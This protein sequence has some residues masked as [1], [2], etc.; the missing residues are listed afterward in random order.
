MSDRLAVFLYRWRK[1]LSALIVL[2]AVLF[3]PSLGVITRIDNDITAWFSRDDPVFQQYER[4]RKEFG[5]TR[6]LIVALKA[7]EG[8]V[9]TAERFQFL[10]RAT[11]DIQR[12]RLVQRADS[13]ATTNIV[14]GASQVGGTGVF[15]GGRDRTPSVSAAG[16]NARPSDRSSDDDATLLVRPLSDVFREQGIAAVRRLAMRDDF[17]RGDLVSDDERVVAIVV[18]FDEDRV[19]DVRAQVVDAVHRAVTS[20]LP[21]GLTAHFNGSLEI[22]ETYNRITLD[23]TAKFTPP[24]LL[25][26]LAAIYLMF[27]S[28]RRTALTMF[29][30]LVSVFWT[31]GLYTVIGFTYNVLTSMLVPLIIVL[32]IADDVHIMQHFEHERRHRDAEAAFKATVSH[33]FAPLLGASVTTAL[34]MLSLATSD[35]VAVRQFG[36]GSAAGIMIDFVISLVLVPTLLAWVR[37]D[38]ASAA[39]HETYLV[40]PLRRVARLSAGRPRLV[41]SI[42]AAIGAV[43]I[44]G[45]SR[46]YVDT[47][48]INFFSKRHPLSTSAVVIDEELSG[49]YSFNILLEGP[50]DSL[51]SPD[52]MRRM[53]RVSAELLRLP[54][55]KK[56]TSVADYVKRINRELHD[57]RPESAVLPADAPAIAQE[58]F[59]FGLSD[60]GR[61]ELERIVARDY[62]RAQMS[63]KLASMSSDLVFAQIEKAEQIAADAFAGTTITPTVTGSGRLFS[64]LDHYL[65]TSQLS[66][67]ATAFVTVFGV[68]FLVFRSARFGVLAIF[69]NLFPVLAVLGM[70]G[71]LDISMNVA[72]IMVSSVALGVVDDDTIHFINRFRRDRAHGATVDR[73]IEAATVFEGR[74]ALTTAII[75]SAGFG[76]LLASEY[77]PTAWFGGLLGLTMATAF[78]A[79]VFVLPAIIKL[80]PWFQG[81]RALTAERAEA[82]GA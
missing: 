29:A 52:A 6:T 76:V 4:F 22:S 10:E 50:P 72:T 15:A 39:P 75:N 27:R 55:V 13:L 78:L 69:P 40:E 74:A 26:T 25:L 42:A 45:T 21:A 61:G 11:A 19:D 20:R 18:G 47:N 68:I 17:I 37:R 60:R 41:L 82:A 71:W 77:R 73:A 8:T 54:Y 5:G 56:A 24:I 53:E 12:I 35:V 80:V 7:E 28:W 9:F 36:I 65:V 49:I 51:K 33:L 44:A 58:L 79:E 3:L 23:N 66:S 59:V 34:G 38:T 14:S 43:T 1:P 16:E 81:E 67:F 48:H 70:M 57:G 30:V 64:T 31:L 32:A 46:L 62:S 2:G 63:V